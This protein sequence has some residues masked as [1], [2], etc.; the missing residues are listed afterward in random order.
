M[1]IGASKPPSLLLDSPQLISKKL[2]AH[3]KVRASVDSSLTVVAEI[4]QVSKLPF[5]PDYTDHGPQHLTA[6]LEI[7][8]KL[9][10]DCAHSLFTS[11]DA[12]ILIFSSL[13]H[14]LALHLSEAGFTT[15]L[16]STKDG[17]KSNDWAELWREFFAVARH[18]DDHM[19]IQIFG[20]DE[21]GAPRT[22][23]KDPMDHYDNLTESDRK[24]IGE[25]IRRHHAQMA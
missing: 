13:L 4:L 21:T 10:A 20:S 25:F 16:S 6:V 22:L 5:F 1:A 8:D 15:L 9:I 12:A 24:L 3:P 18:W 17:R 11:E 19:L 14:D 23:V 2:E 7:A